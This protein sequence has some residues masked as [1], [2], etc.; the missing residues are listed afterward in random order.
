MSIGVQGAGTGGEQDCANMTDIHSVLCG[1]VT[2]K[3]MTFM[4]V[5][6]ATKQLSNN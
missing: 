2:V 1:K 4:Q 3:A 6:F 5:I